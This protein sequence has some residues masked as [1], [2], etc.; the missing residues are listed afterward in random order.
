MDDI[1][2][3]TLVSTQCLGVLIIRGD[4]SEFKVIRQIKGLTPLSACKQVLTPNASHDCPVLIGPAGI[5]W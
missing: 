3:E 5:H 2:G 1:E 4:T